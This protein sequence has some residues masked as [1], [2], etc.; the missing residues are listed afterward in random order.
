M[1]KEVKLKIGPLFQKN[2]ETRKQVVIHVGGTR[3]GKTF[4]ILLYFW[5]LSMMGKN[6]KFLICR[7]TGPAL[8]ITVYRDFQEILSMT[9]TFV[10]FDWNKTERTFTNLHSRSF[11]I[12]TAIDEIEKIKGAEF[13]YIFMNEA[14]QFSYED[15]QILKM[16]LSAPRED[17]RPNQIFLDLNP[18][19]YYSW[20]RD[21]I[22]A[23]VGEYDLISSNWAYNPSLSEDYIKN[24][25]LPLKEQNE[26]LWR[27]Y[28]LGEW[29]KPQNVI[30]TNWETI[31]DEE[32]EKASF[33]W[34]CYGLDYGFNSPTALVYIKVKEN[35]IYAKE[36]IYETRLL[37]TDILERFAELNIMKNVP[38]YVDPSEPNLVLALQ[39]QGYWAIQANN[40]VKEGI[41]EVAKCKICISK[42]S[43]NMIDEIKNYSWKTKGEEVLDEPVKWKDHLMD[44]LRYAYYTYITEGYKPILV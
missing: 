26:H 32:F 30:Y 42:S 24:V 33:E 31:T 18:S 23:N 44:A 20:I 19:D 16:R 22:D 3:A 6:L 34:D 39:E 10:Y 4:S 36:L 25:L 2:L 1:A 35:K 28:G 17:P 8:R 5:Y 9:N 21:Y 13:N 41:L 12:F 27:I 37:H 11:I 15:F 7:K 43:V 38:I 40:K 29:D 14:N